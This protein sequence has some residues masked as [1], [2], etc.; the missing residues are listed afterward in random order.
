MLANIKHV[1]VNFGSKA[2]WGKKTR[3]RRGEVM[4]TIGKYETGKG[5]TLYEV[6]Y[7]TPDRA[8]HA[9]ARV[10]HDARR[11]GVRRHGGDVET[12]G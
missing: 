8:Q 7:R 12:Q 5:A 1:T 9:Q 2:D 6:R 3:T 10:H 11:E 4:A